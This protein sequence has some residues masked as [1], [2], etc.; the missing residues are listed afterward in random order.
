MY[1]VMSYYIDG[2]HVETRSFGDKKSRKQWM[3]RI[4]KTVGL[5]NHSRLVFIVAPDVMLKD[6]KIKYTLN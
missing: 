6:Y 1:G 3:D 2:T 4:N 5:I